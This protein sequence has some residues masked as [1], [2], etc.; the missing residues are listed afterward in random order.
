[1]TYGW[2][3][4]QLEFCDG[5]MGISTDGCLW[6]DPR[7][8]LGTKMVWVPCGLVVWCGGGVVGFSTRLVER[9][10]FMVARGVYKVGVGASLQATGWLVCVVL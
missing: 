8:N 4:A 6:Q 5:E 9:I 7:G 3:L 1:M 2:R 10:L